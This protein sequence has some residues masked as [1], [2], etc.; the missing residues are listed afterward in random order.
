MSIHALLSALTLNRI[1]RTQRRYLQIVKSSYFLFT[2]V[3]VSVVAQT[4]QFLNKQRIKMPLNGVNNILIDLVLYQC[5]ATNYLT[6]QCPLY[7]TMCICHQTKFCHIKMIQKSYI[8][9]DVCT[10]VQPVT[11]FMLVPS[12]NNG[13]YRCI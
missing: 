11:Y 6:M 3:I 2:T 5:D 12:L 8:S 13:Y 9:I 10:T 4:N 7:K 1:V